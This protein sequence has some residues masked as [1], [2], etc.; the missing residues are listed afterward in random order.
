MPVTTS[1]LP[2]RVRA[3]LRPA[4]SASI[5]TPWLARS[6]TVSSPNGACRKSYTLWAITGPISLVRLSSSTPAAC[7]AVHRAELLRQHGGDPVADVPDRQGVEQPGQAPL[8]AGRDAGQQ[9]FRRFLP[10]P[11]QAASVFPASS[12]TGRR[13]CAP[14]PGRQ[15]DRPAC[16]RALR[17]PWRCGWRS[18]GCAP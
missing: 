11:F 6:R 3:C 2:S 10:H 9:V 5:S 7:R 1:V 8:F 17:C 18:S 4:P 14:G 16:R 13:S 12:R 15:V